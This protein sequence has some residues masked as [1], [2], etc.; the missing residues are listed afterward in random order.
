MKKKYIGISSIILVLLSLYSITAYANQNDKSVPEQL[1][2]IVLDLGKMKEKVDDLLSVKEDVGLLKEEV[3]QLKE[4]NEDLQGK[5]EALNKGSEPGGLPEER[6]AFD[7][8]NRELK[9]RVRERLGGG[10]SGTLPVANIV[11]ELFSV[12]DPD[13]KL[14]GITDYKGDVVFTVNNDDYQLV[15]KEN[16]RYKQAVQSSFRYDDERMIYTESFGN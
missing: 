15:V 9:V 2:S 5:I 12:S 6:L 13:N 4:E 11:V 3:N 8:A 10:Y 1:E 7:G 16:D 14:I